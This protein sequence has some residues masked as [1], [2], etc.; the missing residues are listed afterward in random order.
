MKKTLSPSV[1]ISPGR[2]DDSLLLGLD[3]T[4][5]EIAKRKMKAV[6][7]LTNYWEWSGGMAQY[8]VWA[9]SVPTFDPDIDGWDGFMNFSASFYKNTK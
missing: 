9:D 5:A 7:F 6:L 1:S 3:F 4:L 2:Y 8:I